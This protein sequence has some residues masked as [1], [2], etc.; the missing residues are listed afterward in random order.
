MGPK[1]DSDNEADDDKTG[2]EKGEKGYVGGMVLEPKKGLY[3]ER[4]VTLDFASLYPSIM[5]KW[6]LCFSTLVGPGRKDPVEE[7]GSSG[8]FHV[9]ELGHKF[10][11]RGVRKGLIPQILEG[12]LAARAR[13]KKELKAAK[14]PN[15]KTVLDAR[16][17]ALKISANSVYGYTG[18][19]TQRNGPPQAQGRKSTRL[20]DSD[21]PAVIA[22]SVTACG[23]TLLLKT[24]SILEEQ[25]K[26]NVIYGDTDSLMI[27][28]GTDCSAEEAVK[29]GDL[30]ARELSDIHGG[31]IKLEFEKVF[32][33]FL[34]TGKKFYAGVD[35]GGKLTIKGMVTRRLFDFGHAVRSRCLKHILK[36]GDFEKAAAVAREETQKLRTQGQVDK[37]ALIL[38]MKL[39]NGAET[40]QADERVATLVVAKSS[41][42]SSKGSSVTDRTKEAL[43]VVKG[44]FPLDAGYYEE[45]MRKSLVMIF[46][47][48]FKEQTDRKLFGKMA[49]PLH[50]FFKNAQAK[51]SP[52]TVFLQHNEQFRK[53]KEEQ[54]TIRSECERCEASIFD[55]LHQDCINIACP[56]FCRREALPYEIEKVEKQL[57]KLDLQAASDW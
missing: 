9:P 17:L 46:E 41:K 30:A 25:Y 10:V 13:A 26:A 54:K 18:M 1:E 37:H 12:L 4:V 28:M 44:N 33:S 8:V 21:P 2:G 55:G 23:R 16:Q 35:E 19:D 20:F 38:P 52:Q 22:A 29:F 34:L 6:N 14:D 7:D 27:R 51:T 40:A 50:T 57:K 31:P 48:I 32:K 36:E 43:G 5:Q 56:L 3:Q 24:K 39:K 45:R 47:P 11:T 49:G 53:L 15:L 42:G